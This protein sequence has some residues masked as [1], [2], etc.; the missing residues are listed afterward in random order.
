MAPARR[1]GTGCNDDCYRVQLLDLETGDVLWTGT[2]G[3]NEV[4]LAFPPQ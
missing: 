3:E 2:P 1:A 4:I